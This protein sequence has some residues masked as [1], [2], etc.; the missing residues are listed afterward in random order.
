M[1][2]VHNVIYKDRIGRCLKRDKKVMQQLCQGVLWDNDKCQCN[3]CP[4]YKITAHRGRAKKRNGV[5]V[6]MAT[7]SNKGGHFTMASPTW[8]VLYLIFPTCMSFSRVRARVHIEETT[9][10]LMKALAKIAYQGHTATSVSGGIGDAI[11][12][13]TQEGCAQVHANGDL[14]MESKFTAWGEVWSHLKKT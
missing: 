14:D 10:A 11:T 5:K 6:D 13:T 8:L 12:L 2:P 4:S 1:D 3:V 7:T 9:F